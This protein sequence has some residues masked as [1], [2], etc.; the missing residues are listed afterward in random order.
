[1]PDGTEKT[2]SLNDYK[3]KW[4]VFFWYPLDFTFVCP[5]EVI[6]FSDRAKEFKNIGCEVLGAS[7]DS[8]HS[9]LAFTQMPRKDGGLGKMEIPLL[10]DLGGKVAEQYGAMIPNLAFSCR[11]T[12]IIDP[13]GI[14]RHM[15]FN[16]P[17][18]GRSSSET[19]RL[20]Q[21]YQFA[22]ANPGQVCPMNWKQGEKTI[23]VK[24]KKEYFKTK[25]DN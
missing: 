14:V 18:V 10:A 1:M 11:A 16:D 7:V 25:F 23:S 5:S 2:I 15:S 9:H 19:L 6:D 13:K 22:D 3:G 12:Y 4:L 17:P 21:G 20:V 8:F 24:D